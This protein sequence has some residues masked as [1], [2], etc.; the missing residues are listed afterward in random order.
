[1]KPVVVRII[2]AAELSKQNFKQYA[3]MIHGVYSMQEVIDTF[4]SLMYRLELSKLNHLA[5]IIGDFSLV[6]Q[7]AINQE[8]QTDDE[9]PEAG[10]P[11]QIRRSSG[12]LF[13]LPIMTRPSS[14]YSG[15]IRSVDLHKLYNYLC[16]TIA[17]GTSFA[18]DERSAARIA[19]YFSV[20]PAVYFNDPEFQILLEAI[21]TVFVSQLPEGT[22]LYSS[23]ASFMQVL[24][25]F[26]DE[27]TADTTT[28]CAFIKRLFYAVKSSPEGMEHIRTVL[29]A[30]VVNGELIRVK[31][32]LEAL[33][34]EA[35][36]FAQMVARFANASDL[37]TTFMGKIKEGRHQDIFSIAVTLTW[38]GGSTAERCE[39]FRRIEAQF[40]DD[41]QVRREEIQAKKETALKPGGGCDAALEFLQEHK[42]DKG[43]KN[44]F[45]PTVSDP[46]GIELEVQRTLFSRLISELLR[47][48]GDR[49]AS[50]G[51]D[52]IKHALQEALDKILACHEYHNITKGQWNCVTCLLVALPIYQKALFEGLFQRL[53]ENSGRLPGG[54]SRIAEEK[55]PELQIFAMLLINEYLK[56]EARLD[57]AREVV[58]DI[59]LHKNI[60]IC[61]GLAI[62]EC[63][64]YGCTGRGNVS[65]SLNSQVTFQK[66]KL[67]VSEFFG[68][69][70]KIMLGLNLNAYRH[71][72]QLIGQMANFYRLIRLAQHNSSGTDDTEVLRQAYMQAMN[73]GLRGICAD[74]KEARIPD[75]TRRLLFQKVAI[76]RR[77][78]HNLAI[79]KFGLAE[80]DISPVET[81]LKAEIE[82][83]TSYPCECED[84]GYP[85]SVAESPHTFFAVAAPPPRKIIGI[86][87]KQQIAFARH[88]TSATDASDGVNMCGINVLPVPDARAL[89][90]MIL[91]VLN[92]SGHP[93]HKEII[94][95]I[96]EDLPNILRDESKII[97]NLQTREQIQQLMQQWNIEEGTADS[98]P[99]II[100]EINRICRMQNVCIDYTNHLRSTNNITPGIMIAYMMLQEK[101]IR[102]WIDQTDRESSPDQSYCMV[103]REYIFN[104]WDD[105]LNVLYT[106]GNHYEL[107]LAWQED[108]Q[109]EL[110]AE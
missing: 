4:V 32:L 88:Y 1:V 19:S 26:L 69:I 91:E 102:I 37:A 48:L 25:M 61:C 3:Q 63:I 33:S 72:T 71:I 64:V 15:E 28:P 53:L 98:N 24:P 70:E 76:V 36:F 86:I 56:L 94:Y 65:L 74:Y 103:M 62:D 40:V 104:V 92:N 29:Q 35:D 13:S 96:A 59:T 11:G 45:A 27:I 43:I 78:I 54:V 66:L 46:Q 95:A 6:A 5:R 17:I 22:Q 84:S 110:R 99:A 9:T 52:I 93:L 23:T 41:D 101:N 47:K 109:C 31:R 7:R 50:A 44:L 57:V 68:V 85:S 20:P 58:F 34:P 106:G 55:S 10:S 97:T 30:F 14:R 38:Q 60:T 82:A 18:T 42:G 39:L 51:S 108:V 83:G 73:F 89:Y 49:S 79:N 80:A 105:D 12:G 8:V 77:Y 67:I 87:G 16:A 21:N 81:V 90:D 100:A 107:L 75:A 2:A